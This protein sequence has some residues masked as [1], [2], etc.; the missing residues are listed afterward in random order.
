MPRL[1]FIYQLS[2]A[3]AA[4]IALLTGLIVFTLLQLAHIRHENEVVQQWIR[5]TDRLHIAIAAGYRLQD[6]DER[7]VDGISRPAKEEQAVIF[8][9][10]L[11]YPEVIYKTPPE[12]QT[13]IRQSV[14]EIGASPSAASAQA[15]LRALMPGL[16]AL[17][18]AFWE[19]KRAA[20]ANYY[21]KLNSVIARLA[22]VSLYALLA[23]IALAI[24]LS[25]ATLRSVRR[26]LGALAEY[27]RDVC[28]GKL[29]P[30]TSPPVVR[31]EL[32][33]L[34]AGLAAMTQRLIHVVAAENLL[35]GAEQE[36]K[37]IALDLHDQV[38]ADLTALSRN[39]EAAESTDTLQRTERYA[40]LH[41]DLTLLAT[42]IRRV[43]D[44]LHP[45]TLDIL[46]LEAATRSFIQRQ[47]GDSRQWAV[48]LDSD[49]ERALSEFQRVNL[50]R[51]LCEAITNVLRHSDASACVIA[52][53]TLDDRLVLTVEDNG[54][55]IPDAN[56]GRG[57][58]H[59]LSNIRE[60]ALSMGGVFTFGLSS[61]GRGAR[62]EL[63]LPLASA[64]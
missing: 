60:R 21:T 44:D 64:R 27:A 9:E 32:D 11:L 52:L 63:S 2:L 53:R 16:E 22:E 7:S 43:I 38:L 1:P 17:D 34:T 37:R 31:D 49:A 26:R 23:C 33:A 19:Q 29:V 45:Q 24:V 18:N 3:P 58:G 55:G 28:N 57:D 47:A 41:S 46:G 35:Q 50:F 36:R 61:Q 51:I 48:R 62:L 10:N 8:S 20:Y 39:L 14:S 6:A 30:I 25:A 56:P 15:A 5:I 40:R 12:L 54:A 4:I 42:D 59:G 13:R